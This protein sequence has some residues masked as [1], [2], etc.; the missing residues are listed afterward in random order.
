MTVRLTRHGPGA[1]TATARGVE[2]NVLRR[3]SMGTTAGVYWTATF[4]DA[5]VESA[6]LR[7]LKRALE[8]VELDWG[9]AVYGEVVS[10]EIEIDLS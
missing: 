3:V 9:S 6:T 2:W 8:R 5:Y 10:G 4:G 1:Y 7:G